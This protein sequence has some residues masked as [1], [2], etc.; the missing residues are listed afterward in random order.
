MSPAP[1]VAAPGT[2]RQRRQATGGAS[3]RS[4]LADAWR[5]DDGFLAPPARRRLAR[6][7][8]NA[9]PG[10]VILLGV[11][12]VIRGAFAPAGGVG[13]WPLLGIVAATAATCVVRAIR[14]STEG[15]PIR[16]PEELE[17]GAVLVVWAAALA[18]LASP[19]NVE[20]P[21]FPLVYLTVAVAVAFLS[22]GVG[23][24]LVAL[25]GALQVAT[26]WSAGAT[27][28]DFPALLAR[29]GFILLFAVLYHAVM[30]TRLAAARRAEREA[31][32]GRLR[33]VDER[34]REI[35]LLSPRAA[36]REGAGETEQVRVRAA[37][38]QVEAAMSGVMEVAE[39]AL[40]SHTCALF[41]LS[42]DGS[43]LRLRECRSASDHVTRAPIPS[44]EGVLGTVLSRG[45]PLR[46]HGDLRSATCYDDG[47]RPRAL[48]AAPLL[49]RRGGHVRGVLLA[50]RIE[51]RPFDEADEKLL[52]RVAGELLRAVESERILLGLQAQRDEQELFYGAIEVL[53]RK[54]KT[55]EVLDAAIEVVARIVPLDFGAITL[56]E[57][58]EASQPHRIVKAV[59][60]SPDGLRSTELEGRRFAA[61]TGLVASAVRHGASLPGAGER[62]DRLRIFD[63]GTRLQGLGAVRV[64]PLQSGAHVLGT[65]VAGSRLVNAFDGDAARR[66]EVIAMQV[67][68]ALLR[69]RLLEQT[70]R[71]ASTDGLTGL[72]NHRT[73]QARIDDQ[74]R[75]A[76][77][78]G[79][80]MSVVIC[81]VDRFK[82]VNDTH[83][84][85]V[86]DLVLR[87][88]ARVLSSE[89]RETDLVAR[90]GGEEFAIVM[91]E[92]DG[93]GAQVIAERIR[94]R[95]Q[96]TCFPTGAGQLQVTLSLGI[97]TFPEDG[98]E[99][100][101]LIEV[102]DRCLYQ[103]KRSG[104][105]RSIRARDLSA[106]RTPC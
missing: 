86:G 30:W 75:L 29:V 33:E 28:G 101:R 66:L 25:A 26:W 97:A 98:T 80:Q 100:A 77:R 67:A 10:V 87:G 47:T 44:G 39:A 61:E 82:S 78:Y 59:A 41:L 52:L 56:H 32:D 19:G 76:R 34:A 13:R 16:V 62:V 17:L 69:A 95:L 38:V 11:A 104:R 96:G 90:Y 92:T 7:T 55:Q 6:R 50:D 93:A 27:P 88:L 53:N 37:A 49:E 20:G 106:G 40:R 58:E 70:E 43:T 84:H 1:A 46:L 35:R 14:R 23:L 9:L 85:P 103:A 51:D 31:V 94:T 45:A 102:A 18:Q 89:A 60:S 73:F 57:P 63:E 12:G 68:D 99:K 36:D 54:S 105:N 48:L 64:F 81:D 83:G 4:W 79:Q 42:P 74:L 8:A 65:L 72:S 71:L 3:D 24:G 21:L 2:V 22:I 5:R 15:H 91:P